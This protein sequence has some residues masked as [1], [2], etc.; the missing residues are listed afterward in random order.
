MTRSVRM[1]RRRPAFVESVWGGFG[2]MRGRIVCPRRF[3]VRCAAEGDGMSVLVVGSGGRE[4]A[5]V[6]S[7][8]ASKKCSKVFAAPGNVGM[9]GIAELLPGV[10][11][12]SIDDVV[13]SAVS[14]SV[15]LVVVGPEVPLVNGLVDELEKKNIKAFGPKSDAAVL[16]GSKSFMKDFLK[17]HNIPTAWYERFTSPEEAKAFVRSKGAPIVVKADGLAAGKGVIL[18]Q[19]IEEADKAID[20]MLLGKIFGDAG[21]AIIVEEFLVGEEASFF[22]ILDGESAVPFASAQDHKAAYDGDSGPNTGGMGSYS[23]APICSP[24]AERLIMDTVV[25]P[26]AKGMV[27][28]GRSYRGVLF[29]GMMFTEDGLKVLE[30]N[31][32]FGDPECQ[33]LCSR[34][35]SDLLELLDATATGK[36]EDSEPLKWRKDAAMVVVMATEGYP[37]KYAKGSVIRKLEDANALEGVQVFHAGTARKDGEIVA[38][39]GRVLGVTGTGPSIAVAQERAYK[40]VEMVDWP[41][42]FYRKDIGWRALARE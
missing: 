25:I 14:N 32:R 23:P 20:D 30:F 33:V 9:E 11:A 37:G 16:E 8:A 41:E 42:G 21:D 27:L 28:E 7:I 39:G 6:S 5:L 12:E 17:R 4:H 1:E 2:G 34:L 22:A 26:T 13:Q 24:E 35:E 40:G 19:T 3:V 10:S 36:L 29:C 15:D 31:V 18:A 38:N